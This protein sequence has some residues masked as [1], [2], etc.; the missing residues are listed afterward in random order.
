MIP[1]VSICVPNLNMRPY[2][3]ERFDSIFG[4]TLRDW[5]LF[6]YDSHS[7]DGAWEYIESLAAQEPRMRIAQGPR[8]GPYPAWNECVRR[9]GAEYVYIATSDDTMAPDCLEKMVAAL[10]RNP[11]C[12]LA[13]CPLVT[14]DQRG[15]PMA[16]QRW[17]YST[18]FGNGNAE[19][20][21]RPHVRRAPYDGLLHLI[22]RHVYLSITQLVIR[23]SLFVRIGDFPSRWG[24]FS[25]FNWEMKAGL[26][27]STVHVP[28]TWAS[29]R[30]H[31]LQCTPQTESSP[32]A[33]K[34]RQENMIQDAIR[35]CEPYLDPAVVSGLRS[36]WLEWTRDMVTYYRDLRFRQNAMVRRGYQVSQL[37]KGT[38]AARSQ[39][40][41]RLLGR[42]NWFQAAPGVIRNWLESAGLGPAIVPDAGASVSRPV[43]IG[44]DARVDN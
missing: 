33:T 10:E 39:I 3:P 7:D 35:V 21:R 29:W 44:C 36:H 1:R 12:E 20:M 6:V 37:V 41:G 23:R 15:E 9:T 13:H 2:L 31:P 25:D 32:L 38:A 18:V 16:E 11:D 17:P 24:P 26:L 30:I 40:I 8:E 22:R 14:I 4:Q 19:D 28:D 34:E 42:P 5:E 27:A 43:E